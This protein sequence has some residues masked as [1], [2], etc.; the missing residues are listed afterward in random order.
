TAAGLL[1]FWIAHLLELHRGYWAVLTAVIIIQANVGGSLKAAVDRLARTLS[2][3]AYGA[4]IANM[5]P[6]TGFLWRALALP[7]G[8]APPALLAAFRPGLRLAAVTAIIV[9]LGDISQAAG[10]LSSAIDRMIEMGLGS[11]I[12]F[13]VS[14]FVL[15]T[16]AHAQLMQD[17]ARLLDLLAEL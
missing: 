8:V 7:L 6:E 16:R 1:T 14:L 10:A 2:G 17:A 12:G 9:L 11:V 13:A 3:G 15:P 4:L 5:L